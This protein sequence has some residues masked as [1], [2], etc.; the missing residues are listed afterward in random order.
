MW[1]WYNTT[2][3]DSGLVFGV[4]GWIGGLLPPVD[5]GL[6]LCWCFLGCGGFGVWGDVPAPSLFVRCC[7]IYSARASGL[8]FALRV[9]GFVSGHAAFGF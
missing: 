5:F 9:I 6:V 7:N 1:G 3:S 8:L 2:S 4:C